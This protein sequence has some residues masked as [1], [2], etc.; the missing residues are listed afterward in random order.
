[1]KIQHFLPVIS[2]G[3]AR[4]TLTSITV[5][6]TMSVASATAVQASPATPTAP[7]S[8]PACPGSSTQ[9]LYLNT[10]YSFAERAADLVS[11][12]TL[13]EKVQQLHTNSAPAI[14]R[15]GVQQYTYWSEGQHGINT[16]GADTDPGSVTGGVHAT[17]FP[18]NFAATMSWDPQLTYQETTAISDEARGFLD[19]S[20]WDTGQN[21]LG[22]SASD[23]GALTFW[24]PTVNMDRDPRWGRTDEAFGEDPDLASQMADAFVDGY[25]GETI[26]GQPLTPYLKVAATAK[27]YALNNEEDDRTSGSSNTDD[28]NIRDYYT[29]QFKSLVQNAHV[30]GVMTSYNA[31][32][33]TPAV[34]DTYTVNELLQRTYGFNGY[35]TS[36][37]GAI[38]TTYLNP[39]S[40]H[41]W[42]PPGWATSSGGSNAIWTNNT[43]RTQISGA[44][45][46]E[47]YAL[48]AGTQLN[49]TGSEPSPTNIDQAIKAGVLS[50]GVIDNALVHLFTMR[51]E[52]GE[53]DPPSQ[54][55][56]TKITK[57]VIQSPAHQALAE[58]VAADDLVLL[59]NDNV[60]GANS[61]L[62]PANPSRLDNVVIVGNLAN[63][64]T[65]GDYS[66]DPTLQVSAV[67]GIT[68]AVKAAN[69]AA[70]VTYDSCGTSSTA[71]TT[72][73]CSA[74]TL[75]AIKSAD[76]V[77][78]FTGTDLNVAT[79]GHDRTSLEMPGNYNSLISQVAAV[80]NPRTALVIQ[81]NGPVDISATQGDFP[82]IVFSGYNGESQGTALAQVLFGQVD[83]AGHLD[84]TWYA[85]D[86]Q[87]P[88]ISNYGLTPSQTGG[89]GRTYMYFTGTPTYPFGYG[90]S[91]SRFGYSH[92]TVGPRAISADGTAH[93]SFDVTNTGTVP[94]ATVA[95]LY[96]APQFTV[97]GTELPNEQLEGFQRTAVLAPGQTQRIT[98]TVQ[99]SALSQWDEGTLKQVVYDGPYQF[100]IGPDSATVAGSGTV[101]VS[102]KIT[103]RV[104]Y[105]TV[106]PDQVIFKPGDSLH[107]TGKNR[108]IAPDTDAALEQPHAS[109][110]NIVEAI[111]N[112]ESFV[113]L[114]Q[115]KVTYASSNPDVARVSSNGVMTAVAHGVATITVT[116]NGVSGSAPVVVQQPL[117]LNAPAT[118][119]PGSTV[120]VTTVL[121]DAGSQPLRAVTVTLVAPSGWTATATS[122]TTFPEVP[123]GQSAKTTWSLVVPAGASAGSNTLLASAD[124]TDANGP[125]MASA[126]AAVAVPYASLSDAVNNVGISDDSDP[127]AG[128][129]D[130]GGFSYSAEALAAQGLTP[131]AAITHDGVTFT[132]PEAQSGTPDNVAVAGQTI[133]VSG[134]GTTLGLLGASEYGAS[135]ATGTI[136]Y[137]DGSTQTFDVTF[138]DWWSNSAPPGGD[139][140]ATMPYMNEPSGKHTQA[141][142][143]YDVGVPLRAGKTVQYVT[144][145][146]VTAQPVSGS[147]AMHIFAI[148]IGCCSAAL[149]A[150]ATVTAG[151]TATVQ[152]VLANASAQAVTNAS[153]TLSVPAG[154]TA[155]ASDPSTA[156]SVGGGQDLTTN[157]SAA[158]PSSAACGV[159]QLKASATATAAS[160]ATVV[161]PA[162]ASVSITCPSFTA[163]LDDVGITSDSDPGPGNMDGQQD[164]YSAEGLAASGITPGST[165][166]VDGV[167]LT[168]PDV[169]ASQPDNVVAE[170]Q[171]ID[172]SGSGGTM[173]FL[174]AADFGSATGTGTINYTDGTTQSFT[175]TLADWYDDAPQPGGSLVGSTHYNTSAGP[176]TH[177][178]GVYAA[179]VQLKR[180][181]A[182]QSVMLPA[183]STGVVSGVTAMHIFA[184]GIG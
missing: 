147:P 123:P 164:S 174:G 165:I 97:P 162:N 163:A 146:D 16:L 95:Q 13:A 134:A 168:W 137:T 109:A 82:A 171:T 136:I 37:C 119:V 64:V 31:I 183:V 3:R 158:V 153:V 94:G 182:V 96:V 124:F 4:R 87:L 26:S 62:L 145:P 21:N 81:S 86:T 43:T 139:I 89:L 47:A 142:S 38:G 25:Q 181:K 52:T 55:P 58:E 74:S 49:C 91:Y 61:T 110:D 48:R 7:A 35:T 127:A 160:G 141:N 117:T 93:V 133:A 101:R 131:G 57:N 28:A 39:P 72:A 44:A 122:P 23:Y 106:Q 125:G 112:D 19:K 172:L 73:S 76:L 176:G 10:H 85:N 170:G 60:A 154:W 27:H 155:S 71:T 115:A 45:G 108:W 138:P 132:W 20:L 34:A 46:G 63:T 90:L 178:V 121:P 107:L 98:L 128:N 17:S 30:S 105:V 159:Y 120:T 140:L 104:Q 75:A 56:Y 67:Q 70:T 6:V 88:P 166:T 169:P 167:G 111:N 15:L 66:G 83:P 50:E 150:P 32:N 129:L 65:L 156:A 5:A 11:C 54:V 51:M 151:Q 143:V 157:W 2:P 177:V 42:A 24:A 12:M 100:R 68:A 84:F 116:V 18:T 180:G 148:G 80:G 144:L 102:G 36:D 22:P 8:P 175:L 33:G 135:S 130:G 9:P 77:I 173:V 118:A 40:G 114:S 126:E 103:P 113:N 161:L 179:S 99:I 1:M 29:A 69:P 59:K 78:V 14:P 41:D 92:I 149:N 79:E 152:T 53:F 184:I